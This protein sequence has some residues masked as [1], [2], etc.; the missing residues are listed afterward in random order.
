M[1]SPCP[2]STGPQYVFQHLMSINW[3]FCK[4]IRDGLG[5]IDG[6]RREHLPAGGLE[7]ITLRFLIREQHSYLVRRPPELSLGQNGAAGVQ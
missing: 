5:E 7:G 3:L 6:D 2:E 4:R 1:S